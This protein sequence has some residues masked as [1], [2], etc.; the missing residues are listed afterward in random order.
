MA[1]KTSIESLV[2]HRYSSLQLLVLYTSMVILAP[3]C[4]R[5]DA[6]WPVGPFTWK[7]GQS[8]LTLGVPQGDEKFVCVLTRVTGSFR[9][10]GEAVHLGIRPE[11]GYVLG[12]DS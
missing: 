10:L 2:R 9:G 7:Q 8:T 4:A 11:G 1:V 6:A 12:G 5:A 3:I